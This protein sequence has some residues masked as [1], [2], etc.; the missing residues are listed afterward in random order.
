MP[1]LAMSRSLGDQVA[2]SVGVSSVPEVK[3]FLV[4]VDD[5]F[6]VIGSDVVFE[7]L[8][9]EDIA[10]LVMPYFHVNQ[11]EAAA[12]AI[13]KAAYKRWREE[14]E[15]VDDITAVVI[16]MEPLMAYGAPPTFPFKSKNSKI[17]GGQYFTNK[18]GSQ[19]SLTKAKDLN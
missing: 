17:K 4:G 10:R 11:P 19:P 14:E 16:F 1:G 18:S 2:H 8:T 3:S 9:N 15:V 12:N 6:V 5:K 13:V 7:F